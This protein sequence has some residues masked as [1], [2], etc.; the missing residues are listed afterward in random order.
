MYKCRVLAFIW[1]IT[2]SLPF[3][4]RGTLKTRIVESIKNIPTLF[5]ETDEVCQFLECIFNG[6][7]KH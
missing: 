1:L 5:T 2:T 6:D 7:A 3:L 4:Y